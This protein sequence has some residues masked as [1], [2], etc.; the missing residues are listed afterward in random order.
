[1][2]FPI[3]D[4][5]VVGGAKPYVS[6][7]L[8]TLNILI[9]IYTLS[10]GNEIG[11]FYRAYATIPTQL[12]DGYGFV[13]LLTNMFLHGGLMHIAGNMLFLW[14]F[15]DNV[16]AIFGNFWF[17]LFYLAG[18][19]F[20]TLAHVAFNQ[21]SIIPSLGA[22]GALSA[23]MG[24]YLVFFP[25]SK[26][27]VLVIYLFRNFHISAIYFLGL[28]FVIQIISTVWTAGGDPNAAGTAWWA[29]IGGFVFGLVVA[30]LLKKLRIVETE[31]H[32]IKA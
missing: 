19:I 11:S 3:G 13:T 16:E 20:A 4:E 1:M 23:V 8:I 30:I 25:K 7:T 21:T 6:Y 9:F 14:I 31:S 2:I 27:K 17:I 28:W 15:S 18:G 24:A 29:H 10:I 5:N 22:S 32:Y 26:I 12:M